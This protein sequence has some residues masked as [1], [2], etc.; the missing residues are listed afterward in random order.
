MALSLRQG[1]Y[2]NYWGNDFN[3]SNAL[4]M[5]QMQ[6]NAQYIYSSLSANGWTLNAICGM[7]GNMQSES[8]INPRKVGK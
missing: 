2:G 8:S 7:L 5:T 1:N 4:T 3:S 6:V